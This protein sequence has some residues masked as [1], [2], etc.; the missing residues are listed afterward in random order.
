MLQ[1][2]QT[3]S[4]NGG[5]GNDGNLLE[6]RSECSADLDI[7][8]LCSGTLASPCNCEL[9]QECQVSPSLMNCPW[10]MNSLVCT[11]EIPLQNILCH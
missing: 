4:G 8:E 7:Q 1:T 5:S 6:P 2:Q 9:S 11:P 3:T 10:I